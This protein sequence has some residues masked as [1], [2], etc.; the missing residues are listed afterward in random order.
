MDPKITK[1]SKCTPCFYCGFALI[2]HKGGALGHEWRLGDRLTDE[3]RRVARLALSSEL[4]VVEGN[5]NGS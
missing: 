1:V 5:K 2:N 4:R 3:D